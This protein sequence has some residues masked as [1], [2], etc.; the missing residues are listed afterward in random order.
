MKYLISGEKFTQ[1]VKLVNETRPLVKNQV[2]AKNLKL[3]HDIFGKAY[4]AMSEIRDTE[5]ETKKNGNL[6]ESNMVKNIATG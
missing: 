4:L 1:A 3:I 5:P 6:E 2:A